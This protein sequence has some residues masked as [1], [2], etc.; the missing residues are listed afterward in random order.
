ML[1]SKLPV[2]GIIVQVVI[3]TAVHPYNIIGR[4][5]IAASAILYADRK[6]HWFDEVKYMITFVLLS[7][8][9]AR[10]AECMSSLMKIPL[11]YVQ[12]VNNDC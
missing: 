5:E 3:F 12:S 7:L 2:A 6:L 11:R 8:T 9:C 4:V 1:C 10:S